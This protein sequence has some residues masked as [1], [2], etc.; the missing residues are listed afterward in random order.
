[1]NLKKSI[2]FPVFDSKFGHLRNKRL[3]MVKFLA[4]HRLEGDINIGGISSEEDE[5]DDD[6]I[7]EESMDEEDL[8]DIESDSFDFSN[9]TTIEN[10]PFF[11]HSN[12]I[13]FIQ[14]FHIF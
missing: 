6:E 2:K 5:D 4:K 10:K 7:E 9:K 13:I 11:C 3:K 8:E 14:F 12:K 1:M